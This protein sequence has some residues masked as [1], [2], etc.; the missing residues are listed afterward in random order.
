MRV[1]ASGSAGGDVKPW[2]RPSE[3]L[4]LFLAAFG[5]S[6]LLAVPVA[7]A[8][9]LDVGREPEH[10]TGRLLLAAGLAVGGWLA[11][12]RVPRPLVEPAMH[13]IFGVAA[14]VFFLGSWAFH[15]VMS[16]SPGDVLRNPLGAFLALTS[17]YGWTF[18][19][20]LATLL[21]GGLV[22]GR[23]VGVLVKARSEVRRR[24]VFTLVRR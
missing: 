3:W 23:A 19:G 22:V 4:L 6:L 14:G 24:T 20:C 13:R 1:A 2:M 9:L 15:T 8:I 12:R 18:V 11:L 10:A 21:T 16:M 7:L 5:A 17:S